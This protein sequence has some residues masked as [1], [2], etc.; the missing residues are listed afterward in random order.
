[1]RTAPTTPATTRSAARSCSVS[2]A[3]GCATRMRPPPSAR[4]SSAGTV[5]FRRL[6]RTNRCW[7]RS[8]AVRRAAAS[9]GG[10]RLGQDL[11]QFTA[12]VHLERDVAATEQFAVHVQLR[13]GRPV[14]EALERL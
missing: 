1:M 6:Q 8:D 9:G 13:V 7:M 10:A 11:L 2:Y 4:A 3:T 5:L 14:G 12:L